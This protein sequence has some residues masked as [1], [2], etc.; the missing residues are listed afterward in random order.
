MSHP[1]KTKAILLLIAVL[2]TDVVHSKMSVLTRTELG[3]EFVPQPK[4]AR[5]VSF[6]YHAVMSDYYWLQAVQVI[7]RSGRPEAHSKHLGRLIDVVTT[8]NPWV[9]HPYRFAA[10]WLTQD[11]AAVRQ[12]NELLERG[13]AYHPD[14]WRMRFY[15]GFNYYY[16]L[17]E[18]LIAAD[19]LET[20]I[21]LE[22][23]P[24]YLPRMV[25]RLRAGDSGLE[26]SEVFL[27]ELIRGAENPYQKA[28]YEK[29]LD[30][31]QVERQA[32]VLD[33]AR[34]EY[35]RRF[36]KDIEKVEDL[37]SGPNPVL[38]ELPKEM[39]G[40]D[41][42]IYPRT[43]EIGSS[44]YYLRYKPFKDPADSVVGK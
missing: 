33:A 3:T 27:Q 6:G 44:F 2:L 38:K 20:V 11:E 15:L 17:E 39:H 40:V 31:I 5:A 21:P 35:K 14:E 12:A 18:D 4:L 19:V 13:I 7:G 43:G 32:R 16:Y 36:G 30:E 10:V 41:W 1:K 34:E 23:R 26:V 22:G 29:A 25:A 28:E 8:V 37:I 24:L 42:V 9:G